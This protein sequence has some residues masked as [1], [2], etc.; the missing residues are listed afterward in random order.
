MEWKMEY[1]LD[2]CDFI[3]DIHMVKSQEKAFMMVR[4]NFGR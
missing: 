2:F 1:F 3:S 4:R